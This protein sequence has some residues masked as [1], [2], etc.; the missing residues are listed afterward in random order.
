MSGES[1]AAK[2][3][4]WQWLDNAGWSEYDLFASQFIEEAFSAHRQSVD[5][6]KTKCH[7][8]Y[9]IDF[10]SMIQT[11]HYTGFQ[12]CVR[13]RLLRESYN[14]IGGSQRSCAPST[15]V[16]PAKVQD[17]EDA[18][19]SNSTVQAGEASTSTDTT[20]PSSVPGK[21]SPK[22]SPVHPQTAEDSEV[23]TS[24]QIRRLS[25]K[26]PTSRKAVAT[27]AD[28]KASVAWTSLEEKTKEKKNGKC[29]RSNQ[30]EVFVPKKF[31]AVSVVCTVVTVCEIISMAMISLH[32][33]S[34]LLFSSDHFSQAQ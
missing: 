8:P 32:L 5:L 10:P 12:R 31:C 11:K 28:K 27:K 7:L 20:Q 16:D 25:G 34:A 21:L 15:E 29:Y 6:S 18:I 22:S 33:F 2:G 19:L 24:K 3:I 26:R 23:P 13:R 9:I 4:E 17:E 1:P 14:R 30:L